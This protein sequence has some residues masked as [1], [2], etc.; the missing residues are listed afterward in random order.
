[1]ISPNG[2]IKSRWEELTTSRISLQYILRHFMS[3]RCRHDFAEI[4]I[5]LEKTGRKLYFMKAVKENDKV[6]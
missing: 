6:I 2:H 4:S 1:M 5:H 3:T